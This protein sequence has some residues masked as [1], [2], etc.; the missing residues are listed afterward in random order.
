MPQTRYA[1]HFLETH[2]PTVTHR[3]QLVGT[4][5]IRSHGLGAIPVSSVS[6]SLDKHEKILAPSK[7]GAPLAIAATKYTQNRIVDKEVVLF[8]PPMGSSHQWITSIDLPFNIKIPSAHEELP[9]A[10]LLLPGGV[11]ETT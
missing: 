3:P 10:S 6:I 1:V 5:E 8:R 9:S 7:S 4:V 2:S 11:C